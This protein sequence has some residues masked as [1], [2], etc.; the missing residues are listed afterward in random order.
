M[1]RWGYSPSTRPAPSGPCAHPFSVL[2]DTWVTY[3]G[4]APFNFP[5]GLASDAPPRKQFPSDNLGP[6]EPPPIGGTCSHRPSLCS[7]SAAETPYAQ[8]L[9]TSAKVG[10]KEIAQSG[11][12]FGALH[13]ALLLSVGSVEHAPTLSGTFECGWR[14]FLCAATSSSLAEK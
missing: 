6:L 2:T 14:V 10:A 8:H 13:T 7:T 12:T 1:N 3:T 9:G 5:A 11:T 4:A